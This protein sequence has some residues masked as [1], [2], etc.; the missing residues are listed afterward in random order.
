MRHLVLILALA[1]PAP[2]LA[3]DEDGPSLMERGARLFFR[4]LMEEMDP[5]MDRLRAFAEDAGPAMDSFLRE[6][7]PALMELMQ[8][9]KDFSAYHPPEILP[10]G[11]IILRKKVPD[12]VEEKPE[13]GP[14]GEIE[15]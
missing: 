13:P 7:G 4:G 8:D 1:A 2:A 11:D 6:M 12:E 9:V 14:N 3:Q 10:N 5:A 15:L